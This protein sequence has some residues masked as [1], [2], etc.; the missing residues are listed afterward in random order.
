MEVYEINLDPRTPPDRAGA[1]L[2]SIVSNIHAAEHD[3]SNFYKRPTLPGGARKNRGFTSS[4][5]VLLMGFKELFGACGM[6][7]GISERGQYNAHSDTSLTPTAL[8][9]W[10]SWPLWAIGRAVFILAAQQLHERIVLGAFVEMLVFV[11]LA[12]V[13]GI[14]PLALAAAAALSVVVVAWALWFTVGVMSAYETA[15]A[16]P[17]RNA[18]ANWRIARAIWWEGSRRSR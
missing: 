12:Y 5:A 4:I 14:M 13:T 1:Q 11:V 7:I 10:E 9:R 18:E 3:L 6:G 2:R 8:E 17:F 16:L 15:C